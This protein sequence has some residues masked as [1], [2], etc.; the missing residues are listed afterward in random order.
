MKII[1]TKMV[2]G[3]VRM[4][5]ALRNNTAIHSARLREVD[6][7]NLR[8][9]TVRIEKSGKHCVICTQIFFKGSDCDKLPGLKPG[10]Y[11]LMCH[12]ELPHTC[13]DRGQSGTISLMGHTM[14][15]QQSPI[16]GSS[17]YRLLTNKAKGSDM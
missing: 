16:H 15:I 13:S 7:H 12:A 17:P 1:E 4:G 14:A 5:K 6:A 9:L 11:C 2:T 8:K 10:T 3:S